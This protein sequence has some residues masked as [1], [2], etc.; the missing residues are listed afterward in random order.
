M[1][2]CFR[3]VI[4]RGI[5]QDFG[6]RF[7]MARAGSRASF[8]ATAVKCAWKIPPW[9]Q[10]FDLTPRTTSTE[11]LPRAATAD[12]ALPMR[13]RSIPLKPHAPT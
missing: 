10:D 1:A 7:S 6:T 9:I 2:G 13:N 4:K 11:Q 5:G 12:E 8:A 3:S